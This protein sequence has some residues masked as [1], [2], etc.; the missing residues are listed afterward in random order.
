MSAQEGVVAGFPHSNSPLISR[1]CSLPHTLPRPLETGTQSAAW[2]PSRG[3][4]GLQGSRDAVAPG[5]RATPEKKHPLSN[6]EFGLMGGD[7]AS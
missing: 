3:R 4:G 2:R 6:L 1:Y 7:G 5:W